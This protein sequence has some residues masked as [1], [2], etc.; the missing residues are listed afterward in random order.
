M[1]IAT[2]LTRLLTG[3]SAAD[4]GVAAMPQVLTA[5]RR[6]AHEREC[7]LNAIDSAMAVAELRLDGTVLKVNGNFV[8]ILDEAGRPCKVVEYAT[9]FTV[10]ALLA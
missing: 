3:R 7:Q 9:D 1:R 2:I 6:I 10:Q 5:D 4:A 8:K